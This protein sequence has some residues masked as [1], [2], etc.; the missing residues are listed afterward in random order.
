MLLGNYSV[1]NKAPLRFLG[2]S[3]ASTE[4]K[5]RPNFGGSGASRNQLYRDS[6]VLALKLYSV[7]SG[8]TPPVAWMLPQVA[9]AISSH[10]DAEASISG[11]ASGVGGITATGTADLSISI[12]DAE[13]QLITSGAGSASISI[14]TNT[15]QITA[16]LSAQGS[17]N[18]T[19]AAAGN[20]NAIGDMTGTA[21]VSLTSAAVASAIGS[22]I[23]STIDPGE[24]TVASIA[25]AVLAEV[26]SSE[27]I[28]KEATSKNILN[29]TLAG[30]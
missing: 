28:A 1:L 7:P 24:L 4:A 23:G 17:A 8:N 9:G 26:E 15:P 25:T 6:S 19:V 3:T 27:I 18:L 21:G 16:S 12:A 14:Q 20:S 30:L 29:A 22:M 10:S 2:G 5:T 13:G 11:S